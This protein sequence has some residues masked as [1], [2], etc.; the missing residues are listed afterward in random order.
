MSLKKKTELAK[1]LVLSI[2]SLFGIL[3]EK[4]STLGAID[5]GNQAK[6]VYLSKANIDG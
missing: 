2:G 5:G 6:R 1:E 3:K 4:E